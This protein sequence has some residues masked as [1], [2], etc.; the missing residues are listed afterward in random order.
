MIRL[1]KAWTRIALGVAKAALGRYEAATAD[2]D[3][4]IRLQPDDAVAYSNRGGAKGMLDWYEEALT[5]FD[6]AIHLDPDNAEAYIN[7]GI[8]KGGLG[9]HE[10]ARQDSNTGLDLAR[11]AGNTDAAARVEQLLRYLDDAEGS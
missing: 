1:L 3:E 6:H 8:A 2:H 11:K 4:A 9:R 7:R 5:D 10:E